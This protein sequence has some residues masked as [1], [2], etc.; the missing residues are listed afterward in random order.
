MLRWVVNQ[1][2]VTFP[3]IST[4]FFPLDE[5]F[6]QKI[7]TLKTSDIKSLPL[8]APTRREEKKCEGLSS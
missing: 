5:K 3:E 7:A 2:I 8:T 4:S 1:E 6:A